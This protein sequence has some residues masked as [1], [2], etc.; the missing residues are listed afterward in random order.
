[1]RIALLDY[2]G[3]YPNNANLALRKMKAYYQQQ[4]H[5]VDFMLP[6]PVDKLYISIV[7]PTKTLGIPLEYVGVPYEVGGPGYGTVGETSHRGYH[8]HARERDPPP[9]YHVLCPHWFQ[10][11]SGL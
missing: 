8:T 11:R 3:K 9:P 1:M 7:F 4:G 5:T 10:Y 6:P 2:N